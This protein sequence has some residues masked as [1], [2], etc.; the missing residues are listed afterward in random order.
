M[1]M[2]LKE[3]QPADTLP[4]VSTSGIDY[5]ASAPP[6]TQPH[7]Q[8][9]GKQQVGR[10]IRSAFKRKVKSAA[11]METSLGLQPPSQSF[12]QPQT[13]EVR[14]TCSS[15]NIRTL[16]GNPPPEVGGISVIPIEKQ[17]DALLSLQIPDIHQLQ[18]CTDPLGQEKQPGSENTDLGKN[19][20]SPEDPGTLGHETESSGGFENVAALVGDSHLPQLFS[21]LKDLDQSKGPEV[22]KAKDTRVI[23]LNQLWEKSRNKNG[24]SGQARNTKHKASE[25]LSAAPKAKIQPQ[26]MEGLLGGHE[27]IRGVADH[28]KAPVTTSMR[29]NRQSPKDALSRTG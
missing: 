26:D 4:P 5:S 18:A 24:S 29:S 20:L 9:E 21:S 27:S 11:V 12:C 28:D 8:G 3:V 17:D 23:D 16:Q 25:P 15:R 19:S 2:V 22:D 13:P 6:I 1:V 14:K 7:F 10:G